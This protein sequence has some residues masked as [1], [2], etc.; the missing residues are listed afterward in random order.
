MLI[1]LAATLHMRSAG[2]GAEKMD[3]KRHKATKNT[4]HCYDPGS[5]AY[6]GQMPADSADAV[7]TAFLT[8][9]SHC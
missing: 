1:Q 9:M 7:R 4:I 6:M 3:H 8:A 2:H 5:M